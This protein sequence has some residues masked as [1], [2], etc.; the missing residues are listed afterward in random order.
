VRT[1]CSTPALAAAYGRWNGQGVAAASDVTK[2]MSPPV[3]SRRIAWIARR[4]MNKEPVSLV[5][6]STAI[7][8]G[9]KSSSRP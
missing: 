1:A 2:R 8:A 3:S 4:A 9:E 5:A 6:I 7:S